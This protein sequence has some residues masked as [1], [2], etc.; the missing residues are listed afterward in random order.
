MEK[1]YLLKELFLNKLNFGLI[2]KYKKLKPMLNMTIQ[3]FM[4]LNF[5]KYFIFGIV[6][7]FY[8]I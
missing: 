7:A 4:N 6:K 1:V 2:Q 5:F 3:F 8:K